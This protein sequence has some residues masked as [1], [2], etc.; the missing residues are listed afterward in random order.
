[1]KQQKANMAYGEGK[2]RQLFEED[3]TTGLNKM[4]TKL[5]PSNQTRTKDLLALATRREG[6]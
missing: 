6:Q 5:G 3:E 4:L 1:M 2:Q